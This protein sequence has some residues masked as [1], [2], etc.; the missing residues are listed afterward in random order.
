MLKLIIYWWVT[1]NAWHSVRDGYRLEERE[2]KTN[3]TYNYWPF[4][5]MPTLI[6]GLFWIFIASKSET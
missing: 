4:R 2:I 3:K 1:F 5:K 6:F